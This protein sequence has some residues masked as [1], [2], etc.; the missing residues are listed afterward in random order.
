MKT[1]AVA[2]LLALGL[3]SLGGGCATPRQKPAGV[4]LNGGLVIAGGFLIASSGDS[5]EDCQDVSCGVGN[6]LAN[7]G[8]MMVGAGL[9]ISGVVGGLLT[10]ALPGEPKEPKPPLAAPSQIAKKQRALAKAR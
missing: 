8:S 3:A 2:L 4:I 7:A 6:G 1:T 10:L 9:L 5:N